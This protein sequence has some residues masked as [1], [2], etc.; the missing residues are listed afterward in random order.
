M[1][2]K[3]RA[4]DTIHKGE[5]AAQAQYDQLPPAFDFGNLQRLGKFTESHPAVMQEFMGRFDWGEQ[6]QY[7]GSPR[8]GRAL[9]KHERPKYRFL[10]FL[11]QQI[12]G[13]REIFGFKNYELVR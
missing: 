3:S 6:L 10:T 9:H 13:G 5:R 7:S 12:L 2:S 11:E 8:P 4:L 1:R